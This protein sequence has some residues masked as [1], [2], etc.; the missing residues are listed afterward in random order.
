[1]IDKILVNDSSNVEFFYYNLFFDLKNSTK[2]FKEKTQIGDCQK[3]EKGQY[4][5]FMP[6]FGK[7]NDVTNII[8]WL[9]NNSQ[10]MLKAQAKQSILIK[11]I[12][13]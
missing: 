6:Y 13:N 7:N 5:L 3:L 1:M 10:I 12:I 11:F 9:E 4:W 2:F 8:N